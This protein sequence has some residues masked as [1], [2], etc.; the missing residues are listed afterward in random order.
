MLRIG[1]RQWRPAS[2]LVQMIQNAADRCLLF[3]AGENLD[4]ATADIAAGDVKLE[5][6][7]QSLCPAN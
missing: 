6:S 4:L 1:Q 3:N 7:L 2:L 5:Y